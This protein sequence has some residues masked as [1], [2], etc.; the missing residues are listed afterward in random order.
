ME[1]GAGRAG[2]DKG[3]RV[4][5]VVSARRVAGAGQRGGK[6]RHRA[7]GRRRGQP[8]SAGALAGALSVPASSGA[9]TKEGPW[10]GAPARV[11]RDT[12]RGGRWMRIWP[13]PG[14]TKGARCRQVGPGLAG[15]RG[16]RVSPMRRWPARARDGVDRGAGVAGR[17]KGTVGERAGDPVRDRERVRGEGEVGVGEP[18]RAE[19][20]VEEVSPPPSSCGRR[21]TR[22]SSEARQTRSFCEDI[23]HNVGM[24]FCIAPAYNRIGAGATPKREIWSRV[25]SPLMQQL[26]L[27]VATKGGN[28]NGRKGAEPYAECQVCEAIADCPSRAA[29]PI[30]RLCCSRRTS[31]LPE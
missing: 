18:A 24:R 9:T 17:D 21:G 3:C 2:P 31:S 22:R 29:L 4:G 1:R 10:P 30:A 19:S 26:Q 27:V 5:V 15:Q 23:L 16:V 14:P 13:W 12:G 28:C 7:A 11:E 20:K 8:G 6:H 25:L